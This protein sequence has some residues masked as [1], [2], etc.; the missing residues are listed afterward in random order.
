MTSD[1]L[2]DAI[3]A[4]IRTADAMELELTKKDEF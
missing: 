2:S 3:D 4:A 1:Q